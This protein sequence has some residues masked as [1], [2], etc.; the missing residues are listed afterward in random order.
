MSS[1][2]SSS[3]KS[4]KPNLT[5]LQ[6]QEIDAAFE[7]FDT[8]KSGTIDRHEL[9]VALKGMGFDLPKQEVIAILEEYDPQ[10]QELN[11]ENFT[12]A[13]ANLMAKRNPKDEVKKSFT[14]FDANGDRKIDESDLTSII[15]TTGL[16]IDPKTIKEMIAEFA[17]E[18]KDYITLEDF[19]EIMNPTKS[20]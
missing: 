13:V 9:R 3:R 7:K 11:K 10:G 19:M 12:K 18:G 1:R 8:N 17:Q 14:L 6:Q 4:S 15:R 20:Y 16:N 2:R 5:P